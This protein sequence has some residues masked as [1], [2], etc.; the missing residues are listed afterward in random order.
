M[1]GILKLIVG[2][3]PFMKK[4]LQFMIV[5][6]LLFVMFGCKNRDNFS[7]TGI[8]MEPS[9]REVSK[10][11][12]SSEMNSSELNSSEQNSSELNPS[13]LN[14]S[15]GI[16]PEVN[17]SVGNFLV[18]IKG[19]ESL[20]N[21]SK[22]YALEMAEGNYS[23]VARR[24]SDELKESLDEKK[25]KDG[26]DATIIDCGNFKGLHDAMVEQAEGSLVIK[27]ILAYEDS[28]IMV[29]F[30]YNE[31]A[32]IEGLFITYHEIIMAQETEVY[33][34]ISIRIGDSKNPIEG[35]LTMPK[36]IENPPV[37]I[38]VHGSGT[39]D[40]DET[41][42]TIF[43]K[44]FK[45]IACGL[46]EYGIASIR[47]NERF[48]QY[49]EMYTEKITIYDDSLYDV[50]D[51]I[52]Y[53]KSCDRINQDKIFI[54]GHSLGGMMAPKIALDHPD[55]KGIISLAGSPRRLQDII[56]DQN[57]YIL[58]R[59]KGVTEEYIDATRNKLQNELD[60][61]REV[62]EE[63]EGSVL[64]VSNSYWYSLN[65]IDI[66]SILKELTIPMLILQG[67]EDF[68]IFADKDY[69]AWQEILQHREN[70]AFYLYD[71]LNHFFMPSNGRYDMTEY[72]V[73]GKVDGKVIADMAKWIANN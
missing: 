23:N 8:E 7:K 51:A 25:L 36:G 53:A 57:L 44:P 3:E 42:G 4:I 11:L 59:T 39:H 48:Y 40:M 56:L 37:I 43:N 17:D 6:G 62:S 71:N 34:E 14:S 65:Q 27:V 9:E 61:T 19:V 5:I 54:L 22:E 45:D 55:V 47:Y 26:W 12:N 16:T 21:L 15:E 24:L 2:K 32:V 29:V 70:V 50:A 10:E 63:D 64:E 18:D 38:L 30:T 49:P 52:A 58:S 69:V 46:A 41:A 66:I 13:E 31:D 1:Y 20:V 60:K 67:A 68:Q 73:K 35:I 33:D 72:N 28:G